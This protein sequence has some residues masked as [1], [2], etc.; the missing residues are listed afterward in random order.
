MIS[1]RDSN[2]PEE[3]DVK[4]SSSS[5]P[6]VAR[7]DFPGFYGW[8]LRHPIVT[9]LTGAIGALSWGV[10]L[11]ITN[12][13]G[14]STSGDEYGPSAPLQGWVLVVA[15]LCFVLSGLCIA[16]VVVIIRYGRESKQDMP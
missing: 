2:D 6:V 7:S 4:P 9:C 15:V 16:M 10:I 14:T 1:A 11:L 8:L 12:P 13:A 5:E 3:S